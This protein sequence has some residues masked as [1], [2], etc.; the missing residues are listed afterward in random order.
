MKYYKKLTVFIKKYNILLAILIL[1]IIIISIKLIIDTYR[2][3][4][5]IIKWNQHYFINLDYRTD[6]KKRAVKEF[7][8]IGIN[9]P[10]RFIAIKNDNHGGIGCGLSHV[11]VLEKAKEHNWDYVIV[12]EDDIKFYD[13]EETIK[14]INNVFKSDIEWDVMIIGSKINEPIEKINEDC[15]RALGGIQSAIMYIVKR[16][17]YDKLINLWKQ[18]MISFENEI[19]N[20]KN[21]LKKEDIDRIYGTYAIDQTWKSLQKKD[22]FISIIPNKV[23][24]HGDNKSDIWST[25]NK[26]VK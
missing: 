25:H 12:M 17:Y 21:N 14:K 4:N 20:N 8:K 10:N 18:D 26:Y 3:K 5:N 15:V 24:E 16:N 13:P 7:K 23:F 9:N 11:G 19:I 6:R 22:K 1:L 2:N